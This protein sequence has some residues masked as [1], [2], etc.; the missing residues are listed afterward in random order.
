MIPVVIGN[1]NRP[2]LTWKCID[3]LQKYSGEEDIRIIQVDNGCKDPERFTPYYLEYP[4]PLGFT[5]AYNEG[6]RYARK[7]F[8][9]WDSVLLINNDC[10]VKSNFWEPLLAAMKSQP[11]V[12]IAAPLF[13]DPLN[14]NISIPIHSDLIGGHIFRHIDHNDKG[15]EWALSINFTCVLISREFIDEHGLL[16]E[17][18]HT[19]S[20]DIDY[21]L[22]ATQAGWKCLVVKSVLI[23]HE[24]N[25]TVNA[26]PD[27]MEVKTKDQITFLNKWSGIYFN[28]ILKNIPL[29]IKRNAFANVTFLIAD[30]D[31]SI[32]NW[33]TSEKIKDPTKKIQT[34]GVRE[35]FEQI[36]RLGFDQ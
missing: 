18:M 12:A 19:F 2:D 31:G 10:K 25:Q 33:G 24:L 15:I 3:S 28:E 32:I 34:E 5:R 27:R 26:M 7:Q 13:E 35:Q 14:K 20:S 29:D 22:R 9:K 17:S 21:S 1:V 11:K 30:E 8:K 16:D 23:W 4:E 36:K 6:I